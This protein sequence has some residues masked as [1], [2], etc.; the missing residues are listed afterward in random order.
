MHAARAFTV[1]F[2]AALATACAEGPPTDPEVAGPSLRANGFEVTTLHLRAAEGG[3]SAMAGPLVVKFGTRWPP[4]PCIPEPGPPDVPTEGVLV[5]CGAIRNPGGE[6]LASGEFVIGD[7]RTDPVTVRF[8]LSHPPDPGACRVL[9]LRG[10]LSVALPEPGP[11][12]IQAT[13]LT[14][15][16]QSLVALPNPGPPDV[17]IP[18]PGP[19][20]IQVPSPGPPEACTVTAVTAR[21]G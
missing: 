3:S 4:N 15:D 20:D 9:F 1:L 14:L 19:P 8:V 21:D 10:A 6:G 17:R 7:T 5:F 13:F 11:P 2:I 12:E 16:G 18:E